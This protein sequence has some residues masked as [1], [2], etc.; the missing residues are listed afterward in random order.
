MKTE[1]HAAEKK[2]GL[3]KKSKKSEIRWDKENGKQNTPKSTGWS[4]RSSQSKI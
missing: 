2:N 1:K 4:K 3:I